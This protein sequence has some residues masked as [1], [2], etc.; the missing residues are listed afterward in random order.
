M[1]LSRRDVGVARPNASPSRQA[2]PQ[3]FARAWRNSLAVLALAV[4]LMCCVAALV[5]VFFPFNSAL[6]YWVAGY[7]IGFVFCLGA[8]EIIA[9]VTGQTSET[10]RYLQAIDLT[11]RIQITQPPSK[12]GLLA[13]KPMVVVAKAMVWM[14]FIAIVGATSAG[15]MFQ[16]NI[17]ATPEL[18][19]AMI[20]GAAVAGEIVLPSLAGTQAERIIRLTRQSARCQRQRA[21]APES[22]PA[23]S[24]RPRAAQ[25]V[26]C[27]HTFPFTLPP[28]GK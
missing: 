3:P 24:P 22:G 27:D 28:Q 5:E 20:I 12:S 8:H 6:T 2:T 1:T 13:N 25:G 18:T 10:C 16:L 19:L 9:W 17:T 14:M 21:S 7:I 26:V 23:A 15:L 11:H 4:A